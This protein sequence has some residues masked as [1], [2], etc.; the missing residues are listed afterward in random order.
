MK[1]HHTG[2]VVR[3]REESVAFYRDVV[4]LSLLREFERRGPDIDEVIGYEQAYL[5]SAMLDLG[6]GHALELIQYVHPSP[7]E[8][9]TNERSC[10]GAA[11]IAIQVADIQ[12]AYERLSAG[13]AR[14]MNPPVQLGA[15]RLA[16]YLQDPDG[17]WIELVEVREIPEEK[18]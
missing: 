11:H 14:V 8:R 3:D 4:G 13:G 7:D 6:G 16:C 1:L 2:F 17:N 9:P 12:A 5:R 18:S 15:D 10:I